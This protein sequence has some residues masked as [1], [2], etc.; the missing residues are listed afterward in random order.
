MPTSQE[1]FRMRRIIFL[2]YKVHS[3]RHTYL[4]NFYLSK[5]ICKRPE[6]NS[7]P[8]HFLSFMNN[9]KAFP[10]FDGMACSYSALTNFSF[11]QGTDTPKVIGFR[12][13]F[14][15]PIYQKIILIILGIT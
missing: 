9:G 4:F 12:E 11:C 1:H 3:V 2:R 7:E 15:N 10:S 14:K 8:I 5:I 6:V 13:S